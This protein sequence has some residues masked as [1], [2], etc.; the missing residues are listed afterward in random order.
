MIC[1]VVASKLNRGDKQGLGLSR[2]NKH[3][4]EAQEMLV[5]LAQMAHN[6]VIWT[7]NELAQA[8]PRMQK[9]GIQRTVRDVLQIPGCVHVGSDGNVELITLNCK[10]PLAP[11]FQKAFASTL[12]A[13]DLSLI[14]GQIWVSSCGNRSIHS[15]A[16]SNAT[17]V[18]CLGN[19]TA[20]CAIR[21][22]L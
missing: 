17:V 4:F 19:V 7:R 10:H 15:V 2:R 3:L 12:A 8:D 14:L 21:K 6:I 11:V 18:G 5:L 20:I 1:V 9:Y 22:F 13:D 16:L